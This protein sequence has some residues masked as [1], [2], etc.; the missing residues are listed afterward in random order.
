MADPNQPTYNG[1]AI[2]ALLVKLTLEQQMALL[3]THPLFTGH[4]PECEMPIL[5][6]EPPKVHWDCSECG[7]KDDSI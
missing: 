6:T 4:C 3:G 5:E 1:E 2:F 7:W